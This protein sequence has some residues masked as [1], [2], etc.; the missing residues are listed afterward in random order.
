MNNQ[1]RAS[2]EALFK[3]TIWRY[4]ENVKDPRSPDNQKYKFLHLLFMIICSVICGADDIDSILNYIESKIEWFKLKLGI[5][6]APSYKAIWWILTLVNPEELHKAF[7]SFIKDLHKQLSVPG[8][9][10]EQIAIDGKTSRGTKRDDIKALHLVS[11]WSSSC[12][13]LLGQV[14]TNEKSNEIT[15]IPELLN[16]LCLENTIITIDAMGCQKSIAKQIVDGG[17]DYI[18]A[19]KGNQETI[20]EE[21]KMVFE[22]SEGIS[23]KNIDHPQPLFDI[24]IDHDK[25]HG[26]IEERIVRVCND[27]KWLQERQEWKGIRAIIEVVSRRLIKGRTTEERRYYLSSANG[28]A[29]QFLQWIRNHWAVENPL[30]WVL[31]V[32]FKDDDFQGH[33][34]HIAENIALLKRLTLNLLKQETSLKKSIPKKRE[35]AGWNNAYLL[36]ILESVKC[37]L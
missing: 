6:K 26:R 25:G 29:K 27:V 36:K 14:K 3:N 15:A 7:R 17:G 32:V 22:K 20:H 24:F 2:D 11:A 10:P 30:H 18:L 12:Q 21:V 4:F 1:D 8:E 19:L 5:T 16:I 13:L 33:T 35:R 37:F 28:K 9:E 31:D 34:G 23:Q